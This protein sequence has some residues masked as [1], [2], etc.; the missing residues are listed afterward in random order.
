MSVGGDFQGLAEEWIRRW[1]ARDL[2]RILELYAEDARMSSAGI[3]RLGLDDGGQLSGKESL[4]KYW[5]LALAKVPGLQFRLMDVFESPDSVIVRYENE[6]GQTICEYLRVNP[7]GQI[8]QGSA[9]HLIRGPKGR[10]RVVT[11]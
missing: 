3:V 1:N 8:V 4:R 6:R 2:E 10:V 7:Q 9:N 5:S 11:T